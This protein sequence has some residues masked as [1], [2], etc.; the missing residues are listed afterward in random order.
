VSDRIRGGVVESVLTNAPSLKLSASEASAASRTMASRRPLERGMRKK[1]PPRAER[2]PPVSRSRTDYP[3]LVDFPPKDAIMEWGADRLP[4]GPA[5][6]RLVGN[7]SERK[8]SGGFQSRVE[9]LPPRPTSRRPALMGSSQSRGAITNDCMQ[10]VRRAKVEMGRSP[11]SLA[12]ASGQFRAV[13]V[14]H[15]PDARARV[16]ARTTSRWLLTA[17]ACA[18]G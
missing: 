1:D 7:L 4:G 5:R 11:M 13:T 12:W 8:R 10:C 15:S 14:R 3:I 9:Q 16:L 17:L 2:V 18:S 6:S